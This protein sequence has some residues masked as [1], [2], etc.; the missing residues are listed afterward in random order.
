M[1]A[2][3]LLLISDVSI[4]DVIGGAER[5]LYEQTT[6]LAARGHQVHILTRRLPSHQADCADIKGVKEWR[7]EV[8][9]KDPLS[10]WLST[11]KYCRQQFEEIIARN[12]VDCINFHQPFSAFAALRS[13]ATERIRKIYTC[14]SLAF[15]EYESRNAKPVPWLRRTGY[16]LQVATRRR[17]ERSVLHRMERIAV[18]SRYTADK[19]FCLHQIPEDKVVVIPGG[20]DLLRFSPV[21]DEAHK[22]DIRGRLGLPED[23]MT[24]LTIRNLVPRMG[25]DLLLGAMRKILV[26]LPNIHLIIGGEG[27]LK[28][29]LMALASRLELGSHVCFTGFI[30]ETNLPEYYRAADLFILPTTDLEGF[31]LVTLE[32]MASGTPV[33]GSPIGGTKEILGRFDGRF[34]FD[35]AS[36][37]AMA[38]LV[39]EK[40]RGYMTD[41]DRLNLDSKRA[42][43][44]VETH[45]SWDANVQAMERLFGG[46]PLG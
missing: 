34:L 13:T 41:P 44:F 25:I 17:L 4:Q 24:L 18:L 32:A 39:I 38:R 7:Y 12:P 21:A 3:N 26:L 29:D 36:S 19:L 31:G 11:L 27:P 5:V 9:Q 15:E 10:F 42:R 30:P 14:H 20:I 46:E 1:S 35:E 37:E 28:D 2:L 6:R 22:R 45:Y 33:L 43:C 23:K 8:T 40:C 16:A